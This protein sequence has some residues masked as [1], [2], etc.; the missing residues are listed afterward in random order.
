[1]TVLL[2]WFSTSVNSCLM[3]LQSSSK[4][5]DIHLVNYGPTDIKIDDKA[6][7]ALGRGKSKWIYPPQL[8]P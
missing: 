7:N 6:V 1:M 4:L 3:S 2:T 8:H 5:Y